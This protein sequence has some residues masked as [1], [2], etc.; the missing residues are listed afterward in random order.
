MRCR[1][2]A[3]KKLFY[4]SSCFLFLEVVS[5]SLRTSIAAPWVRLSNVSLGLLKAG[6]SGG[7]PSLSPLSFPLF[8]VR[9][10][11]VWTLLGSFLAVYWSCKLAQVGEGK[12]TSFVDLAPSPDRAEL[13]AHSA[14]S[15][16][17]G[18]RLPFICMQRTYQ[19]F[20]SMGVH[21]GKSSSP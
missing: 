20:S 5:L 14:V 6:N 16:S 9:E 2:V 4:F 13:H 7:L 15:L 10:P 1:L 8:Y 21:F 19:Q 11:P 12:P 18:T 17:S 3:T